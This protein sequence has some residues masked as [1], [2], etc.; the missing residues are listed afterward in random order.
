MEITRRITLEVLEWLFF[1][2]L[3]FQEAFW[4]FVVTMLILWARGAWTVHWNEEVE[5]LWK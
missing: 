5:K 4:F 1:A 2:L 3:V